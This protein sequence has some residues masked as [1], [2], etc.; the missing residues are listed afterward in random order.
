MTQ[1]FAENTFK[2]LILKIRSNLINYSVL[3]EYPKQDLNFSR[4]FYYLLSKKAVNDEYPKKDTYLFI[5][6]TNPA[7]EEVGTMTE[8]TKCKKPKKNT[9][10][11]LHRIL[12]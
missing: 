3:K 2:A 6:K 9:E 11:S 1:L 4:C 8:F 12:I 5:P 7:F 10:N